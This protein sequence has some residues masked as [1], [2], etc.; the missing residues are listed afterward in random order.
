MKQLS[1]ALNLSETVIRFVLDK[2]I[3][4]G[5]VEGYGAGRG[6]NYALSHKLYQD[7]EKT[8]GYVRQRDIDEARYQELIIS[9][10][11]SSE[12]ISRADVVKLL[13]VKETKAYGLLKGLVEQEV[14]LPVN[15]GRYAKYKFRT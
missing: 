11:R 13:H 12:Y 3:E 1:D 4:A 15:K 9:M 14:L 6:R 5:L 7:K 2:A 10:A 8:L